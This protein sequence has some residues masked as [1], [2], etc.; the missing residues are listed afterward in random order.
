MININNLGVTAPLKQFLCNVNVQSQTENLSLLIVIYTG[1]YYELVILV[2]SYYVIIQKTYLTP[3]N[4]II[5]VGTR[6]KRRIIS[7]KQNQIL[8]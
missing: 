5:I 2:L 7:K 3:Y 6:L 1:S 4:A 8:I